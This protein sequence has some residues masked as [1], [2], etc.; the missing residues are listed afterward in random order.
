[1]AAA[2]PPGGEGIPAPPAAE[3]PVAIPHIFTRCRLAGADDT[4]DYVCCDNRCKL[5]AAFPNLGWLDASTFEMNQIAAPALTIQYLTCAVFFFTD[6]EGAPAVQQMANEGLGSS[7][8]LACIGTRADILESRGSL[9]K[10]YTATDAFSGALELAF[11]SAEL[12]TTLVTIYRINAMFANAP[13]AL[14]NLGNKARRGPRTIYPA[15][16]IRKGLSGAPPLCR[17]EHGIA[18]QHVMIQ[19]G[20]DYAYAREANMLTGPAVLVE[21]GVALRAILTHA[22]QWRMASFSTEG[23]HKSIMVL[24]RVMVPYYVS[25]RRAAMELGPVVLPQNESPLPHQMSASL[26]AAMGLASAPPSP[27]PNEV[28]GAGHGSTDHC[29]SRAIAQCRDGVRTGVEWVSSFTPACTDTKFCTLGL[30]GVFARVHATT[31]ALLDALR[32]TP[33]WR[34]TLLP[35]LLSGAGV[36]NGDGG[37]CDVSSDGKAHDAHEHHVTDPPPGTPPPSCPPSPLGISPSNFLRGSESLRTFGCTY[38]PSLTLEERHLTYGASGYP[39]E[40]DDGVELPRLELAGIPRFIYQRALYEL[41]HPEYSRPNELGRDG[42]RLRA[43][44]CQM[45]K[46]AVWKYDEA[47]KA[48]YEAQ[49]LRSRAR[50]NLVQTIHDLELQWYHAAGDGAK[51]DRPSSPCS[52]QVHDVKLRLQRAHHDASC[53]YAHATIDERL[54]YNRV[55]YALHGSRR[56]SGHP[57]HFK[58]KPILD[59]WAALQAFR[60]AIPDG[61]HVAEPPLR[62]VEQ[63]AATL[64]E[65]TCLT[66]DPAEPRALG[67]CEPWFLAVLEPFGYHS[68]PLSLAYVPAPSPTPA[69]SIA[70]SMDEGG[71][72][73]RRCLAT[74]GRRT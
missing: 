25:A 41:A 42:V 6:W 57:L 47:K 72:G 67:G 8:T 4:L 68:P 19:A 69:A 28:P 61:P 27:P 20:A 26:L 16:H 65:A 3:L 7:L 10:V 14:P 46:A 22:L 17:D 51:H 12:P 54:A 33:P 59:D 23:E 62:T 63:A 66:A 9:A 34:P 2:V 71:G 35:T 37:C 38:G 44:A 49:R 30:S 15:A 58:E 73:W 50:R 64:R 39:H 13:N 18:A 60:A 21:A 24:G 5:V 53:A 43:A 55:A 48:C 70:R 31:E 40:N 32:A 56:V 11:D 36:G 45:L 52:Y 1:M 74:C 29:I